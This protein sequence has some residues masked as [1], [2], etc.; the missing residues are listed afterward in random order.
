MFDRSRWRPISTVVILFLL[1][2]PLHSQ[3][4]ET[5]S[6]QLIF[7]PPPV[8]GVISLGVYDGKGKL[9]RIL[10]K[11]AGIDSFKSGLNGLF[12]DWDKTDIQGKPV[13]SG[14]YFARGVLTGDVKI[15]GV[16]FHLNDW[17]GDPNTPRPRKILSA[18]LLADARPAVLSET[19]QQEYVT[20]EYGD[21]QTQSMPLAFKAQFIKPTG[22]NLLVF[23]GSQL[24]LVAP[25]AGTQTSPQKFS[26]IR[27]ADAS[28]DR[29][30]VLN[31]NQ[32]QYEI[33]GKLQDVRPPVENLFRCAVLGSSIVVATK[34]TKVYGLVGQQFAAMDPGESGE[35]LDL[36][37]GTGNTV[38]L[39]VKTEGALL[40]KQIDLTGQKLQEIELPPELRTVSRIAASRDQD[41]LLLISEA[42]DTQRVIGVRFQA[43]NQ[44]KSVWEKWLDRVLT[45]FRFFDL[46]DGKVIPADAK[47]DSPPVFVRPANNP[48]ENTRQANF[49]LIVALND[50]G[51]WTASVDGLPLFQVCKTRNVKQALWISD[52]AN[53]MR[54][55]VSD[56]IV[57]EEYHLTSLENLFRFDAGAFD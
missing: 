20:V 21:R 36:S 45:S 37:A 25:N 14:K 30:L 7:V 16:A 19:S 52:G 1:G 31:G 26:E 53:G 46:K 34:E 48:M 57:V 12:I 29:L 24:A 2:A 51:A 56:G 35:L 55:Y 42:V 54:V 47:T 5:S 13:P 44:G 41:A 39:L 15:A 49:Q 9:V 6:N 28:G 17:V 27:D 10:K 32:I 11:G 50:D 43:A 33:A 40:L 18:A 22:A 4:E 38:W 8:E 23:D 3:D